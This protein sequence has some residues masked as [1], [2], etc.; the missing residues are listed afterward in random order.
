MFLSLDNFKHLQGIFSEF[1]QEKG[2]PPTNFKKQLFDTMKY[3]DSSGNSGTSLRDANQTTLKMLRTAMF[4]ANGP[5]GPVIA[6]ANAA[7]ALHKS[8]SNTGLSRD[9]ALFGA[10][11]MNTS[12][13]I[14]PE[15]Q[16]SGSRESVL[17]HFENARNQRDVAENKPLVPP[18]IRLPEDKPLS[19]DVFNRQ[20][21]S[22]AA[23]RQLMPV[24]IQ[25]SLD[26]VPVSVAAAAAAASASSAPTTP[27]PSV[28]S[29]VDSIMQD[30]A[31]SSLPLQR[32][33][34]ITEVRERNADV[35]PKDAYTI[36]DFPA[37]PATE[38][39]TLPLRMPMQ[40][41]QDDPKTMIQEKFLLIH[42]L[43]RDWTQQTHRYRYK[44]KFVQST[45][46]I[47]K[48][49]FYENN[50]TVPFTATMTTA[51]IPNT[52]GWYDQNNVAHPSYNAAAPRG[53]VVG[54]EE[55]VYAADTN[56]N[57]QER[58]KNIVSVQVTSVIVPMDIGVTT[59]G[60]TITGLV[61]ATGVGASGTA[62]Y[63]NNNF[64][65]NYPYVLLQI[66]EFND[67]YDGTDDVIRRAFCQLVVDRTYYS[68][69]G[70]GYIIL[71]PVQ[72]EKKV[73]YPTALSTLPT[74]SMSLLKPNGDIINQSQD[75]YTILKLENDGYNRFYIK[76]VTN[77]FF[78]KNEFYRGDV[79]QIRHF[80]LFKLAS[81]QDSTQITRFNQ[82]INNPSGHSIMEIGD[83]ND[84]G[85][86][87]TFYIRAPG[88]FDS[89]IGE[90]VVDEPMLAQLH[91]FNTAFDFD[92]QNLPNGY[93]LNVSL[94][95]SIS[96]RLEQKVYDSF[97]VGSKN[98]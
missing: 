58:F 33:L 84:N 87:R 25:G 18:N 14:V 30:F 4:P 57:V 94:Q 89:T 79:V 16:S 81:S 71:R 67:V 40:L 90:F 11:P 53:E 92:K 21:E 29:T 12:S 80:T 44:V 27:P 31:A 39:E 9:A 15:V 60:T 35:H 77:K 2:V 55:I 62:P 63:F 68:D 97:Q 38:R 72:S 65:F 24:P 93:I 1:L 96:M 75:G 59:G 5:M 61:Q 88:A 52:S 19:G 76:V 36:Q 43:D 48:V 10:R 13:H 85:F 45:Q 95:N 69:N 78:E 17:E 47:K 28:H 66:D 46:E 64:N 20:L 37:V 34:M 70:R 51:G 42:S 22:M 41:L 98:V 86:Y 73:F 32:Q 49:P 8:T 82:F 91:R 74:L 6:N 83:A 50:P 26:K 54:Y 7:S 3:V 23:D 56:A